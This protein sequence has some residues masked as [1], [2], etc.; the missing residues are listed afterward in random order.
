[1]RYPVRISRVWKSHVWMSFAQLKQEIEMCYLS[2]HGTAHIQDEFNMT[3]QKPGK[4]AREYGLR[5]DKLTIELCQSMI[6]GKKYSPEQRKAILDTIQEL[7]L[8]NFQ[9]ALC[10]DI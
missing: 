5:I 3:R 6:E 4:S 2:K 9:L 10:D 7:A 1:M 8:K